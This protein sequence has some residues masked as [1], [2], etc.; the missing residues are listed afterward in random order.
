[1]KIMSGF[2]D[3]IIICTIHFPI[4]QLLFWGGKKY[5]LVINRKN[6]IINICI[7]CQWISWQNNVCIITFQL[8]N[9]FFAVNNNILSKFPSKI[10]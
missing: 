10:F 9:C 1:M 3:K 5:S 7:I 2:G 8:S 6:K 4:K